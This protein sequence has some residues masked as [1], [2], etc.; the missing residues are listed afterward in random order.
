MFRASGEKYIITNG[1]AWGQ[2]RMQPVPG[3]WRPIF[4]AYN[5]GSFS[6]GS[7]S[8]KLSGIDLSCVSSGCVT[9]LSE[10]PKQPMERLRNNV[11]H[12]FCRLFGP[13]D[14]TL[15]IDKLVRWSKSWA[16]III[17]VSNH[18]AEGTHPSLRPPCDPRTLD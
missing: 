1:F 18:V 7:K 8:R 10:R 13:T 4:L 12:I 14:L 9:P 15:D 17:G 5:N 2:K 11:E 16:I 3:M 6:F